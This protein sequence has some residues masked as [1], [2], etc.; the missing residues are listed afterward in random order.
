MTNISIRPYAPADLK[1]CAGIFDRAWRVSHPFAPRRIDA[2]GLADEIAGETLFVAEDD[3]GE[4]VGF[5][6]IYVPE[7]FIH[8]LYVEP[9][10]RNRGIGSALLRHAV[11]AA[12]GSA[13]LKC[14]LG[15]QAGLG[16]YR[17]LGWTEVVAGTNEFGAWVA[18]RSPRPKPG[19]SA[20][21]RP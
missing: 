9:R 13:T 14:Q 18:L 11:T 7:S 15:N 4:V 12:G 2:S 21:G 8:H 5:V 6:A 3:R 16:F 10:L 17:H 20:A 1:V 19:I